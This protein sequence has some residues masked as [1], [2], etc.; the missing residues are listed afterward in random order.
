MTTIED[1]Q[2]IRIMTLRIE[3]TEKVYWF[4]GT[5]F[6]FSVVVLYLLLVHT[7]AVLG[8]K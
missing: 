4:L 8:L 3:K 6:R 1:V 2:E 7:E 5:S